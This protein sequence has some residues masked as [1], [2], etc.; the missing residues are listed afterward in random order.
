MPP[1]PE[2]VEPV[3]QMAPV[4]PVAYFEALDGKRYDVYKFPSNIGKS[5]S[6]DIVIPSQYVS[7]QHA[8]LTYKDGYF[9]LTDNNSSNGT[10]V[11]GRRIHSP[12]RIEDGVKVSFG[13][14]E[15]IFKVV[16]AQTVGMGGA[17]TVSE[18]TTWNR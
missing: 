6:N 17:K 12:T 2:P 5:E 15:T 11:N 4:E 14:Y 9:Y 13:P 16:G 18:K 3:T 10:K 7:R 8:T 1:A